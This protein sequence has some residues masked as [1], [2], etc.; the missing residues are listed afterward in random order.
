MKNEKVFGILFITG[1]II[2]ATA[3]GFTSNMVLSKTI[4]KS[5]DKKGQINEVDFGPYMQN[6]QK[7]IKKQWDPPKSDT[8]KRVVLL[9]TIQRE[10]KIIKHSVF[11]SSG[12]EETDQ[13]A[14]DA[15]YKASPFGKLPRKFKG[16][17][18]DVQFTF[19]YNAHK[20]RN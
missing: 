10:G 8:S 13:A 11:K 7:S 5:T 18:V 15:L 12:D 4:D 3:V 19:D 2:L 6:L 17:S 16:K 14:I 9:F 20:N 1:I